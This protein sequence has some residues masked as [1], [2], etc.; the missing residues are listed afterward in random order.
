MASGCLACRARPALVLANPRRILWLGALRGHCPCL[1]VGASGIHRLRFFSSQPIA[2]LDFK[3]ANSLQGDVL[4][5]APNTL[6]VLHEGVKISFFG[7]LSLNVVSPPDLLEACPVASLEDLAACKLAALV[8]RIEIKDYLDIAAL[9]ESGLSL[10]YMLG[11]ADAVY[12]GEFPVAACLKSLTWFDSPELAD[13]SKTHRQ[14]LEKAAIAV[15]KIPAVTHKSS[16]I[17]ALD[18]LRSMR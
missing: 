8:N 16:H 10:A 2:P 17:G 4:Q 3:E 14:L 12:R 11:C 9:L 5:A 15:E 7:G 1:E 13:L 6:S 18:P